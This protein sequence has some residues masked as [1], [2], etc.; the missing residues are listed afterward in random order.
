M[1]PPHCVQGSHGADFACPV[2]PGTVVVTKGTH[3][4]TDSYSGFGDG[5]S[6]PGAYPKAYETSILKVCASEGEAA[7]LVSVDPGPSPHCR[8]ASSRAASS[9]SL[10]AALRQTTACARRRSTRSRTALT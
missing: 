7:A 3:S 2:A 1:W 5:M 4:L 6:A 9:T 10:F 8:V